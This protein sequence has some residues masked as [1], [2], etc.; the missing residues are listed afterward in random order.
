MEALEIFETKLVPM[1][2]ADTESSEILER[3]DLSRKFSW[4]AGNESKEMEN[5]SE[6]GI[7]PGKKNGQSNG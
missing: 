7:A 1:F 2:G 4:F 3:C 5:F 6:V